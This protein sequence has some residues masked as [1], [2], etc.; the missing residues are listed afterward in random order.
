M[1]LRSAVVLL[2]LAFAAGCTDSKFMQNARRV[3]S[4]HKLPEPNAMMEGPGLLTGKKGNFEILSEEEE[5]VDPN[6]PRK[7]KRQRR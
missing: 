4:E 3:N 2:A 5:V 6:K 7:V 1:L